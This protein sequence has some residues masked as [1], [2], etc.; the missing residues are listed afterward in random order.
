MVWECPGK[1]RPDFG[2]LR[3]AAI[4]RSNYKQVLKKVERETP[5][6]LSKALQ[7]TAIEGINRLVDRTPVDTGAAKFHWFVRRVPDERFDKERTDPSGAKPKAQGEARCEALQDRPN[8]V[9][10]ELSALLC[11]PR[12][13]FI[14]SRHH[15]ASWLS[16]SQRCSCSGRK[17][18]RWHFRG[19]KIIV[20]YAI[21]TSTSEV[22]AVIEPAVEAVWT[23]TWLH[24][25]TR[26]SGPTPT[27]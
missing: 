19:T 8:R 27:L 12:G 16:R 25:L 9:A 6:R 1:L 7:A 15:R 10:C 26:L 5:Q 4:G 13:R 23:G 14:A 21:A 22:R 24:G 18:F 20:S 17:Q 11:L 2:E 3:M